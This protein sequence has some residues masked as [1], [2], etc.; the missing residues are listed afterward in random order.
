[1]DDCVTNCCEFVKVSA[2][3]VIVCRRYATTTTRLRCV[4]RPTT[5]SHS[6]FDKSALV[7]QQESA[8]RQAETSTARIAPS[9][10][11]PASQRL[12]PAQAI[13]GREELSEW[14]FCQAAHPEGNP[15]ELWEPAP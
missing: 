12:R 2:D 8:V 10:A 9:C 15:M 11:V 14:S 1:M 6:P 13:F 3:L 4:P 7:A 5:D